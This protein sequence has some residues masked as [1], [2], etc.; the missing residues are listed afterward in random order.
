MFLA[1]EDETEKQQKQ[2]DELE[3]RLSIKDKIIQSLESQLKA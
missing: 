1:K 3:N 2:I